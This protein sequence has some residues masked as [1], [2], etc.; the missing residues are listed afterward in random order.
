MRKEMVG[1]VITR[2]L[3]G[4]DHRDI[5]VEMIDGLFVSDVMGFFEQIVHAKLRC[6]SISIDWYKDHFLDENRF[7]KSEVAWNSGLNLKTIGNK[8]KSERKE[9]VIE[10]AIAHHDK[11]LALIENLQDNEVDVDLSLTLRG[12]TVHLNLNESLVVIN[13]L[14]VRRA[15]LR[16]GIWSTAGKQVEGPLMEVL[17]RIFQV[18]EKHFTRYLKDDGSLR[19]VDFYLR[20]PAGEDAKCEVKLMGRGNPESADAV[21]ARASRVFVASTLS[22]TNK[23]QLDDL[24]V[25]WTELQLQNGFLRFAETLRGLGIPFVELEAG[26]DHSEAIQRSIRRTLD[27]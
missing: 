22:D 1:Q 17:C 18:D 23:V 10:E 5:I 21:I 9:I 15:A 6:E 20:T 7:D 25:L 14:A 2:A 26:A 11:F 13:A 12:V 19:E 8:R 3:T 16:G 24:G 27:I 4:E